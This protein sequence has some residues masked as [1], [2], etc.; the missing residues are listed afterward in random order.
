MLA[1][2]CINVPVT[3][4]LVVREEQGNVVCRRY[5]VLSS[6]FSLSEVQNNGVCCRSTGL[7]SGISLIEFLTFPVTGGLV[8]EGN[9][10]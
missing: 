6:T 8:V 9:V 3:D 1:F 7:V 2:A 4:D 10:V 5:H